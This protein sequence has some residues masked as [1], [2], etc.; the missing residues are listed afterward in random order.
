MR[1]ISTTT[2]FP[3]AADLPAAGRLR[4]AFAALGAAERAFAGTEEGQAVLDCLGG[5]APYLAE[6]AAR[7]SA[8]LLATLNDGPEKTFAAALDALRA[9]PLTAPRSKIA[10]A[11]RQAK[12]CAAL[13]IAVA[14]LG[15]IWQLPRSPARSRNWR[16]QRCRVAL[17]HLLRELH[18]VR[19]DNF[20]TARQPGA[21]RRFCGARPRQARRP[22]IELFV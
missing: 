13:A 12:R 1:D 2:R 8:C 20:A 10:A 4:E 19:A 21:R 6:L 5:N 17:R 14:D 3:L 7:E 9:L 22:G 11:L 15:N 18:E 16:R